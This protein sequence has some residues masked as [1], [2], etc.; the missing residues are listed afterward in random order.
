MFISAFLV[1]VQHVEVLKGTKI[2]KFTRFTWEADESTVE[3]VAKDTLE[4]RDLAID[5]SLKMIF[6]LLVH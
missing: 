4:A 1:V 5:P 2:L 3:H 6:F